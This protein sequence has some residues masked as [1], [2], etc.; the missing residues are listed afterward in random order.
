M[1]PP[2]CSFWVSTNPIRAGRVRLVPVRI[3]AIRAWQVDL[4]LVEGRYTWSDGRYVEVF[5]NTVVEVET[6]AGV[7]GYAE[8]CPLGPAYLP[9]HAPGVRAGLAEL[10]PHLIGKD[11]RDLDEINRVMDAALMGHPHAKAPLDI[12]CWDL[13]GKVSGLPVFTLLGGKAQASAPLY[14]A[15]SQHSPEDMAANV[16]KY[17]DE[18]YR[19]FQLKVGGDPNLDIARIRAVREVL[20]DNDVLVAD[21]NTGWTRPEAAR[22]VAAVGDLDVYIE[23]PCVTPA[24]CLSIRRRTGRPFILDET[25]DGLG[26]LLKG[27]AE[28][29]MDVINLKISKV[30]GLTRARLMRD[31]CV[32]SGVPMIIEDPWG[33]DIT[34]AA[35]AHLAQSTPEE[36]TFAATDFNSYV[37]VSTASGAPRRVA[38]RMA[39]SDRPGLGIEPRREVLGDPVLEVVR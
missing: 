11:P 2:N 28:D 39:A 34:T 37:T 8:A 24:E 33:C 18:G 1:S 4:P 27:L 35:V 9:A 31:I 3:V 29:A 7:F 20:A 22:V 36:F 21:A 32:A 17:R 25:I 30:G 15:I 16:A 23:Q 14:R 5:D 10:A 12:A 6:D 38:G 19:R 13:L 26:A